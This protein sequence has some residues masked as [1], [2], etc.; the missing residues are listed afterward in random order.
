M[1]ILEILQEDTLQLD[2]V[3]F[4]DKTTNFWYF[5]TEINNCEIQTKFIR[6]G[7]LYINPKTI[8]SHIQKNYN[9]HIINDFAGKDQHK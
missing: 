2:L 9:S 8:I 1:T 5:W 7:V 3:I 6:P 4:P